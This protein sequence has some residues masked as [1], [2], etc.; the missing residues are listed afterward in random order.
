MAVS[1]RIQVMCLDCRH[2]QRYLQSTRSS[3]EVCHDLRRRKR[4]L[5]R[6]SNFCHYPN[7]MLDRIPE[8]L[9]VYVSTIGPMQSP[10]GSTTPLAF[11][12]GSQAGSGLIENMWAVLKPCRSVLCS[13]LV[14]SITPM[15]KVKDFTDS[16]DPFLRSNMNIVFRLPT[17][18]LEAEFIKE[19]GLR[20]C[21]SCW[22]PQCWRVQSF[23]IM[24]VSDVEE[25]ARFMEDFAARNK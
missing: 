2:V 20:I 24:P 23:S 7:D 6:W 11:H 4:T 21:W 5:S 22:A 1:G 15:N 18:E 13:K 10:M 12:S 3:G 19:A 14:F 9:P 8:G 16:V 25:L 17:E